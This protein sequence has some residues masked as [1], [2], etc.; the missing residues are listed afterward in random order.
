MLII[1]LTIHFLKSIGLEKF[2]HPNIAGGNVKLL[3]LSGS[4]L[5]VLTNPKCKY[6]V[7]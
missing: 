5:A 1:H 6:H 4:S 2:N 3:S 7:I